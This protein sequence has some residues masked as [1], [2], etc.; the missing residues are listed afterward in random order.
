MAMLTRPA[1]PEC[2]HEEHLLGQCLP[3]LLPFCRPGIEFQA[4]PGVSQ[5]SSGQRERKTDCL[6]SPQFSTHLAQAALEAIPSPHPTPA[7]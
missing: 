3:A 2:L 1:R 5:S 4:F 7:S 6:L